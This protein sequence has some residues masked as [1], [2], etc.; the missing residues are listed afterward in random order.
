MQ[1]FPIECFDH[2]EDWSKVSSLI[3]SRFYLSSYHNCVDHTLLHWKKTQICIFNEQKQG[4][5]H[6]THVRFVF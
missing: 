5:L 4:F 3:Y 2:K 1:K 6:A